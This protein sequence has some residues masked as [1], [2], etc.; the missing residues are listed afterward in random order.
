MHLTISIKKEAKHSCVEVI[1]HA[2]I[3]LPHQLGGMCGQSKYGPRIN[4]Q[5]LLLVVYEYA[6]LEF[7]IQ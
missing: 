3:C 5:G 1:S 6:L 2:I 7:G 4:V